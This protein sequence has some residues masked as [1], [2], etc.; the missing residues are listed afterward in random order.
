MKGRMVWGLL[1][2]ILLVGLLA[3]EMRGGRVEPQVTVV[4]LITLTPT[5][6]STPG[7]WEAVVTW[8]PSPTADPTR[9]VTATVKGRS[10][11][12]PQATFPPLRTLEMPTL[13]P[14]W[15]RRP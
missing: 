15:T 10:T 12:T 4:R 13:Q 1:T 3:L 5:A 14:A 11:P 2:G 9:K 7:W 6:R 8:T